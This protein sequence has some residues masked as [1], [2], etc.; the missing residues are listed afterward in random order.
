MITA[1]IMKELKFKLRGEAEYVMRCTIRYHLYN[2]K[3][4]NNTYGGVLLLVRGNFTKSNAH[5]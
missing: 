1:S 2:F 5:P 4:I 3:N